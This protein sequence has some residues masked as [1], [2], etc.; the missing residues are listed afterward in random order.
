MSSEYLKTSKKSYEVYK[1]YQTTI[2]GTPT[3]KVTE[4]QYTRFLVK[5]PLQ[6]IF[7]RVSSWTESVL[8]YNFRDVYSISDK[9]YDTTVFIRVISSISTQNCPSRACHVIL[10]ITKK[11]MR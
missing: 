6:V 1:K 2:H 8:R 4:Q 11:K 3:E 9:R 7:Y 10:Q 5:S